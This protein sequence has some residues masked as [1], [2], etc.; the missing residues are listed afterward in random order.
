MFYN[1]FDLYSKLNPCLRNNQYFIRITYIG[2]IKEHCVHKEKESTHAICQNHEMLM[3]YCY[4]YYY[5][6]NNAIKSLC[7]CDPNHKKLQ[8]V[9]CTVH[10]FSNLN[11]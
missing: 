9:Q 10:T 8:Y 1:E 4:Y 11:K 3:I 7:P 2:Y 6:L 5:Y